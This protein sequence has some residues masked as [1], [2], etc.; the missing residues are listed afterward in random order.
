LQKLRVLIDNRWYTVEVGELSNCSVNVSVDDEP[1]QVTITKP[2][3]S[4]EPSYT[5]ETQDKSQTSSHSSESISEILSP[6]PGIILSIN[7]QIAQIV[8]KG[9]KLCVIEAMKMEQVIFAPKGGTI[10]EIHVKT[11]QRVLIGDALINI[12]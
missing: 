7:V 2:N 6:L 10:A 11:D 5:Y 12:V 1:L 9:D 3:L 8:N 4:L